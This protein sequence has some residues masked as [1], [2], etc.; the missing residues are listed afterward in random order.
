MSIRT[1]TLTIPL[2][3]T[4]SN[5]VEYAG[6]DGILYFPSAM[7]GATMSFQVSPNGTDFYDLQNNQTSV[8]YT[9]SGSVGKSEVMGML[10]G[11]RFVRV[12]SASA[13]GAARTFIL[14]YNAA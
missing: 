3:G 2:N 8:N 7:T 10:N 12:V 5:Y 1:G 11:A 9:T 4:T 6:T 13:E 14:E